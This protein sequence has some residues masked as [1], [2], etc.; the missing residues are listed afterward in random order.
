MPDLVICV[1]KCLG[2]MGHVK[3]KVLKS[4]HLSNVGFEPMPADRFLASRIL[5]NLPSACLLPMTIITVLRWLQ[6]GNAPA[7]MEGPKNV[8]AKTG[9]VTWRSQ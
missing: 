2:G 8:W 5:S 9:F 7:A 1:G 3:P 4:C 6:H